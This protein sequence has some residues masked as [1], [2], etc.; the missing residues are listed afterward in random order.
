VAFFLSRH[1]IAPRHV[2][3]ENNVPAGAVGLLALYLLVDDPAYLKKQ[4][5]QRHRRPL[6]FDYIG[7]RLLTLIMSSWE[8]MFSK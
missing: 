5:A 3:A 1:I 7:L 6:N 2:L 4:R 8:V